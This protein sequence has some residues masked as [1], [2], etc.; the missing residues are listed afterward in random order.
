MKRFLL[1]L[2]ADR[3]MRNAL[4]S[5][6]HAHDFVLHVQ[7]EVDLTTGRIVAAEALIRWNHIERGLLLPAEFVPFAQDHGMLPVIGAWVIGQ[8]A[9]AASALR[10]IDPSF[11]VWFNV[12][13]PELCD[14]RWLDRIACYGDALQG[15]GVEITESVAIRDLPE[16]LRTLAA[17]KDAGLSIA[18]DDF[19]TGYSSL[20]QLKR[21]PIDVVK[22][23]RA[24]IAGFPGDGRDR[25]I[26]GAIL[27]IGRR[28]GFETVAEG[29]ETAEQAGAL[30]DAGC[31]YG[32]GYYLGRPMPV[33]TLIAVVRER[34]A[35]AS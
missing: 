12:S 16:T 28:F 4:E 26:V 25:E 30:H 8:A 17:I 7:P 35:L 29:I 10:A 18:L 27:K 6:I 22:L 34:R 31:R 23:D 1:D 24:F 3:R 32:Q 13:A 21:L 5:A 2:L 20:A 9:A 33:D 15:L 19:G 11:R 14:P